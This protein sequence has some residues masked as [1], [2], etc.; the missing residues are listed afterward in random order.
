MGENVAAEPLWLRWAIFFVCAAARSGVNITESRSSFLIG[1]IYML[2]S[3]YVHSLSRSCRHFALLYLL[4]FLLSAPWPHQAL[5]CP[6]EWLRPLTTAAAHWTG[7]AVFGLPPGFTAALH[8]DSTGLYLHLFNLLPVSL[9]LLAVLQAKPLRRA[10][11]GRTA[12]AVLR[13]LLAYQLL[14]Y[15]WDK[16]FKSQFY[17]PE[18]NTLYTKLGE[19]T[20][21]LL[22]WSSL[23]IS[24]PYVMAL[25]LLELLAAGLLLIPAVR[26]A[27]AVLAGLIMAQVVLVNFC[28]DVS[29]KVFSLFLLALS[30]LLALLREERGRIGIMPGVR[31]LLRLS[32]V[33]ILVADSLSPYLAARNFN[34]DAAPRP[35]LHGAY[36]VAYFI[37][38]GDSLP[39]LTTDTF[40]WRRA[41]VHRR[42]YFIIQ[43]MND[44]MHDLELS[45]DP[46][47]A[48]IW[49]SAPE[50]ST[51]TAWDYQW[52]GHM[53]R[54]QGWFGRDSVSVGMQHLAQKA[55]PLLQPAFHWTTD[56]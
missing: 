36:E 40:R 55:L 7:R 23:G 29:V 21:D 34:D 42:G 51:E 26:R 18:P 33:L 12:V 5:P 19:F 45:Y 43:Q 39:P 10:L 8:S 13:N 17:L 52:D 2:L 11:P 1:V 14:I 32:V 38:N 6:G 48:V 47:S 9:L 56:P 16:L 25:G 53:L 30:A 37:R 15:G 20:P 24:R 54:L 46:D 22:Y 49:L 50:D 4:L 3:A 35:A 44:D 27:G 28:F 41:F 31:T